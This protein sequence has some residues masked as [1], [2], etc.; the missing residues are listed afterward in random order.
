MPITPPILRAVVASSLTCV[1]VAAEGDWKRLADIPD[2]EGFA[3]P[4]AGLVAGR[5]V[6]AGGANFPDKKPWEGGTKRWY[7]RVFALDA[8]DGAWREAGRLP[9]PLGYG[10]SITTPTGL[11]C[12]GGSDADSHRA[13]VFELRLDGD[14]VRAVPLPAL[15]VTLANMCGALVGRTVVVAGGQETPAAT[16]ALARA[17][18]LDLD[19]PDDGWK[20]I[21][22]L[23]GR[24]RILA[25]AGASGDAFVIVGGAD[26]SAGPDG[27]AARTWLRDA[28]RHDAATGWTK[29]ADLPRA[30]VAAPSPMPLDDRGRLLLLG[31]DDGTQ[32]GVAPGEHRG[33]PR[34]I[35]AWEPAADAWVAAGCVGEGLVTTPTVV[36]NGTVVVPGG[37]ARPGIRSNRVWRR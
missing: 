4:F 27:K 35:L 14:A 12:I 34:E 9:R 29:I 22:P 17:W 3:G 16:A 30:A 10:V 23:P 26:L 19:R 15:P 28:W 25:A 6:V 33:F 2:A 21:A 13:E 31:G 5:L 1:A 32:V 20:E 11:L 36:W 24:G 18:T 8:A 7:D 37:E